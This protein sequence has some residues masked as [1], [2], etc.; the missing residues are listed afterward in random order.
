VST[1]QMD[2][3]TRQLWGSAYLA[4]ERLIEAERE[5]ERLRAGGDMPAVLHA[6]SNERQARGILTDL[7]EHAGMADG[8]AWIV[9]GLDGRLIVAL[10]G[11]TAT[12]VIPGGDVDV[13]PRRPERLWDGR[14]RRSANPARLPLYNRYCVPEEVENVG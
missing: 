12:V 5:M 2:E 10:H 1:E 8:V 11:G 6:L 13:C 3:R 4:A 7:V 9:G 14:E